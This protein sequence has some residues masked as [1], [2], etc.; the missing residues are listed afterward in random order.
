[1]SQVEYILG[2]SDVEVAR[3]KQQSQILRPIT[4]RLLQE[5]GLKRG[6]RVLD[7]GCGAGDV[8]LLAAEFVGSSGEVIGI[9]RSDKV[10]AV[11]KDRA[12]RTGFENV[13]FKTEEFADFGRSE[14]FDMVVGRYVLIHQPDPVNMIAGAARM[15]RPG[16]VLA[17]HELSS[18]FSARSMPLVPLWDQVGG[19]V[20]STFERT[21]PHFHAGTNFIDYFFPAGLP[22]PSVFCE[23]PVGGGPDSPLYAWMANVF[24]GVLPQ[25]VKLGI[26]TAKEADIDTLE[27]RLRDAVTSV[28][29]QVSIVAQFCAWARLPD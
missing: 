2:H 23:I 15:V 22:R 1:M 13:S 4:R 14:S 11:A 17:F 10:V 16:G 7:I 27:Q 21:A 12:R 29:S 28:N 18:K 25:F 20:S 19:W 26:G 9:D 5:A 6:M 24:R 8:S 3:L